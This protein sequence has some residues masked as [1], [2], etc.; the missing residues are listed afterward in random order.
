ME[1]VFPV[2][3]CALGSASLLRE[4][5]YPIWRRHRRARTTM[6]HAIE[7]ASEPAGKASHHTAHNLIRLA[8]LS[9]P[10]PPS[11]QDFLLEPLCSFLGP[12]LWLPSPGSKVALVYCCSRPGGNFLLLLRLQD[13]TPHQIKVLQYGFDR[14]GSMGGQI[15][16]IAAACWVNNGHSRKFFSL[17]TAS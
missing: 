17:L 16:D 9:T 13:L 4:F 2:N 10:H 6:D 12:H 3:G 7:V 1:D 14:P 11:L 15:R 5:D 8:R